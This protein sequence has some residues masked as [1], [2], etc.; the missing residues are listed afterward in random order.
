MRRVVRDLIVSTLYSSSP[1]AA[2]VGIPDFFIIFGFG[3]GSKPEFNAALFSEEKTAMV[4]RR[5]PSI[6]AV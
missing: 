2:D 4:A 6:S 5:T 3:R 1:S